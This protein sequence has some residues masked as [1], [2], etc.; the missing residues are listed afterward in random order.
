MVYDGAERFQIEDIVQ[1]Q[2]DGRS[3][4]SPIQKKAITGLN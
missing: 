2:M 1:V 4:A 3:I